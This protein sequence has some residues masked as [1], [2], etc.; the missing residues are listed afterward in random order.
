MANVEL[1]VRDDASSEWQLVGDYGSIDEAKLAATRLGGPAEYGLS[2]D[3]G[4]GHY[5]TTF[6]LGVESD[7]ET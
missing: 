2:T 6:S 7:I 4:S 3:P 1:A 5:E